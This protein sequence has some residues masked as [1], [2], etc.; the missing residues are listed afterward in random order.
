MKFDALQ[1]GAY[2]ILELNHKNI[3]KRD[4]MYSLLEQY[5]TVIDENFSDAIWQKSF[6]KPCGTEVSRIYRRE[7]NL[8]IHKKEQ[9]RD[10]YV[11]LSKN[12]SALEKSFESVRELL[13]DI[14]LDQDSYL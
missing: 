6:I 12:M 3:R 10:F 14:A 11:Y 5:K 7:P 9:W 8:N 2:V 1:D 4:A 13:L